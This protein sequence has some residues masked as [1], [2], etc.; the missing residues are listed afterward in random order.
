MQK[1]TRICALCLL[2]AVGGARADPSLTRFDGVWTTVVACA[3]AG[4]AVPY[5]YE[6]DSTVKNGVLHGERGLKDTPGWLE[7]DGHIL[8]D[9]SASIAAHG[10]VGHERAALDERPAGTP[11]KYGV[12]ARFE[13]NAGKGHRVRGRACSVTFTR[14]SSSA[15]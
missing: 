13:D 5:S 1:I 14:K 15:Q 11:Y 2:G 8:P 9:G 10:V 4:A 12:D 3:V 7:L 6:F